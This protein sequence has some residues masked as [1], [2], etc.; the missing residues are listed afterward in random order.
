WPEPSP[1]DTF[2][3]DSKMR[4]VGDRVAAVAAETRA[5][6]ERALELIDVEYEVLPAVLDAEKAMA[7][8]A[9]VIHD[10]PDATKIYDRTRNIAGHI[11]REIGNVDEGFQQS[12]LIIER[13]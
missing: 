11:F 13:E 5:I 4:F 12:D 7:P 1:Y 6:A 9:P 3:L 2:L 8:G 10:E